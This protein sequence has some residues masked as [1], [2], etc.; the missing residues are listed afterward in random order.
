MFTYNLNAITTKTLIK[1]SYLLY[2][3][4]G[5][6]LLKYQ[7]DSSAILRVLG[8]AVST[9]EETLEDLPYR[10]DFKMNNLEFL[11][12]DKINA[13]YVRQVVGINYL[14]DSIMYGNH[15]YGYSRYTNKEYE[16]KYIS[17]MKDF[18]RHVLPCDVFFSGNETVQAS[19]EIT[20]FPYTK[21]TISKTINNT[22]CTIRLLKGFHR[23]SL[24]DYESNIR[25]SIKGLDI[26][27]R[28]VEE[29]II[30]EENIDYLT[31]NEYSYI[32]SIE[33]L[34]S[35][36][37]AKIEIFPYIVGDIAI[38]RSEIVDKEFS[39]I[40]NKTIITIDRTKRRLIFNTIIND[41]I[42]YPKELD[43]YKN[44]ELQ[45]PIE[46]TI[47]NHYIDSANSL[48]YIVTDANKLY[49]F[50]LIIPTSYYDQL[51]TIKTEYQSIKVD[52]KE[53]CVDESYTFYIFPSTKVNDTEVLNIFINGEVYEENIL[54]DLLKTNIESNEIKI[55]FSTLFQSNTF[56]YIEFVT[57]GEETS[58]TP[59]YIDKSVLQPLYIKNLLNIQ[60][61]KEEPEI[62]DGEIEVKFSLPTLKS[63]VYD[64]N[65][66]Y[67]Y[68][69]IYVDEETKIIKL[70]GSTN[71]LINGNKIVNV[72]DAFYLDQGSENI[73]THDT[74]THIRGTA[75]YIDINN[76]TAQAGLAQA[77]IA[78]AG[79]L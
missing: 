10:T 45:I 37:S 61:F 26:T 25:L 5:V 54:L 34:G 47:V 71:I 4:A 38:W 29:I 57:Y 19:T 20:L 64:Y 16:L 7:N 50:P 60:D 2:E 76:F 70:S 31:N 52:Y 51:D 79:V 56:A 12:I 69:V 9:A 35:E 11:S 13:Y 28:Y 24:E 22:L 14:Y 23:S 1:F 66:T 65:Q 68:P 55:P 77:G 59:I 53:D 78:Q 48:V 39:D 74:I 36:I 63:S 32:E 72:Y 30:I 33:L 41:P 49:C 43:P 40:K 21:N 67:N 75:A 3:A 58:V 73:V 62:L 46:E 44:I 8:C 27:G 6:N 42:V 17:N 18:T 15:I